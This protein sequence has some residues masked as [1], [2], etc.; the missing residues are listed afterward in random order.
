M[1]RFVPSR[2][3]ARA[4]V[5]CSR[6]LASVIAYLAV[7]ALA[8]PA[9]SAQGR[10]TMAEDWSGGNVDKVAVHLLL[11]P[12]ANNPDRSR[13]LWFNGQNVCCPLRG[14]EW[15][16]GQGNDDC[17]A[18]PSTGWTALPVASPGMD[19]FCSGHAGLP[20][21]GGALLAGGTS[22][23]TGA[24][25]ENQSRI[26]QSGSNSIP[27]S[28]PQPYPGLLND[29]RWYPS[30]TSL[31]DR[32][33]VTGGSR[34]PH[35]RVL[36]G[37]RGAIAPPPSP[38]WG[39]TLFRFAPVE[40][41]LWDAPLLPAADPSTNQRPDPRHAHSGVE[42]AKAPDFQ[43]QV[44]FGGIGSSG[45][46]RN[47]VWFMTRDDNVLGADY[48]Y[49]WEKKTIN[50]APQER[51]D[52]TAVAAL[53]SQM[54]VF[55]GRG[56]DGTARSD[57]WRLYKPIP[58]QP[59]YLWSS[60]VVVGAPTTP[61]A[62]CGHGAVYD[63]TVLS[64][65]GGTRKRM[66]VFGGVSAPGQTPTDD[67]VWELRWDPALPNNATWYEMTLVNPGGPKPAPR[68]W[69]SF[70]QDPQSGYTHSSGKNAHIAWLYG[71][72][73]GGGAYSN[74]LWALWILDD[75]TVDWE[76]RTIGPSAYSPGPR[77]RHSMTLDPGQGGGPPRLYLFGG[78]NASGPADQYVYKVDP[79]ATCWSH[80]CPP[81][82]QNTCPVPNP[83]C[84]PPWS[85]W[86][87][88]EYALVGHTMLL[89]F[90]TRAVYPLE[91]APSLARVAET[92]NPATNTYQK[93]P[94]ANL[95]SRLTYPVT[96][97]VPGGLA[98]G[99][100]V[101]SVSA[102]P[103]GAFWLD[104]PDAGSAAPWQQRV[105]QNPGFALSA[106]AMYRPGRMMIAGGYSGLTKSVNA[107]ID[108]AWTPSAPMLG[109]EDHN[110]VALP[111][112]K[113]L[114]VGGLGSTGPVKRPQIWDPDANGGAGTWTPGSGTGTLPEQGKI[115]DYHSTAI[116]LQDARVLSAGGSTA[117]DNVSPEI[118]CPPYLFKNDGTSAHALRP[119][120]TGAPTNLTYR[121]VFTVCT[122]DPTRI[123][124]ACLIRPGAT[125]HGFDQ[126]QR[127]VP[128]TFTVAQSGPP[129]LFVT[130]PASPD[131]A[132]PGD[133]LL[134]L[135]GAY[136]EATTTHYR[137]VPSIAKWLRLTSPW[138]DLCD[139]T[140]AGTITTLQPDAVGS[141]SIVMLWYAE[142]DDGTLAPSGPSRQYHMRRAAG[143]INDEPSWS[144]ATS[145]T[146]RDPMPAP[147]PKDTPQSTEVTGLQPCTIYHLAIRAEDDN[148]PTNP[149]AALHQDVLVETTCGGGG[150]F[151]AQ[152]VT[153]TAGA[154][155]PSSP[156]GAPTAGA[157]GTVALV[158]GTGRLI[159]E[160]GRG[161]GGSWQVR[162]RYAG[163]GDRLDPA[164][165]GDLLV[166]VRDASGRW[167]TRGRL[168]PG[169]TDERLGVC[170]LR[171]NARVVVPG[172][173]A[174]EQV[175]AGLQTSAGNFALAQAQ[176]SRLGELGAGFTTDGGGVT[177]TA[178][179]SLVVSYQ[180]VGSAPAGAAMSYFLLRRTVTSGGFSSHRARG[181]TSAI[182][183]TAFALH[184]SQPN[185][186]RGTTVIAFDLPVAHS[187]RLEVFD[188]LG[189]QVATLAD[190][191]FAAGSHTVEWDLLDP[192]GA[193]VRPG[194]YV[195]RIAAGE[196]HAREKIS[197]LP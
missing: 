99:C 172:D 89:E 188:L 91:V 42:M 131:S 160:P 141:N 116:L 45:Q 179:D 167:M 35:H 106:A 22:T 65:G 136:D 80:M 103:P 43:A 127:Y 122:P 143:L 29:W 98:S 196:F 145:V 120:I 170:S 113:V 41:G 115:R 20:A 100:R 73:L 25:G 71:G 87:D 13:I 163:E 178:G 85:R 77:A 90:S 32:V 121:K 189:R 124:R 37:K 40:G 128:L 36:F 177:M 97:V 6:H 54:V 26:F 75:G 64:G 171:E 182:L 140:P 30:A 191:P 96:F 118:F 166:Q 21:G 183:P 153:G 159:A 117:G 102:D 135:T 123:T 110:L 9:A 148:H 119:T 51:S 185:P 48:I 55:G 152:R 84:G 95:Y 15:R 137:D 70:T 186:A 60:M 62:R 168:V 33:L 112:G 174:L 11:L 39:D 58:T 24:Y 192:T 101:V 144:Q 88:Y 66:I 129:R 7:L 104:I 165:S 169:S 47:D 52:H 3:C 193:R 8:V 14:G 197:V 19:V 146:T 155:G 181:G 134:F 151:A 161:P 79:R 72:A 69:H 125:T 133:Y 190:G 61:A 10:W 147:A 176:H 67:K 83:L 150:G 180:A 63:E 76:L 86:D 184:R 57:V 175:A 105:N 81:G 138:T 44:Y 92:Y 156:E 4:P 5:L 68:Y 173:Y 108:T 149:L 53:G 59:Q 34:H 82:Q 78:E 16:W 142:G 130:A 194:V 18:L 27:G 23:V 154:W 1:L 56:L 195:Y 158:P 164:E 109:R 49:K 74:Q 162:L 111:D 38:S 107:T 139:A 17:G 12:E 157:A 28:W 31:R 50:G 94:S 114:V 2:G 46:P 126:N 132:P 187:V 93:H